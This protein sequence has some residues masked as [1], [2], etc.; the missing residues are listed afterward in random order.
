MTRGS[1]SRPAL[2]RA[3]ALSTSSTCESKDE[4]KFERPP[5]GES[6]EEDVDEEGDVKMGNQEMAADIMNI[7][8]GSETGTEETNWAITM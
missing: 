8:A 4:R 3:R 7:E 6:E 5:D 1:L 2:L